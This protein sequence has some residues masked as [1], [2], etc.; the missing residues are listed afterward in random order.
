MNLLK[1]LPFR[2]KTAP[3]PPAVMASRARGAKAAV[4]FV[5]GFS[6]GLDSWDSFSQ[7]LLADTRIDDWDLLRVGYS[8]ALRVDIPHVWTDDPDLAACARL[9]RTAL[10]TSPLERYE[11]ITLVAHSMGGLV[12]QR[13]ILD[14]PA[15]RARLAHVV[16]YGTPSA[17]LRKAGA[18]QVFKHQFR[19]MARGGRFVNSVRKRWASQVGGAPPFDFMAV[20]GDR[21]AFV[22]R[23]S[24][25]DP[26]PDHQV[27]VIHGDHLQIIAPL[28]PEHLGYRVLVD[29]LSGAGRNP[30]QAAGARLAAERGEHQRVVDSLLPHAGELDDAM[31]ETLALSL[32]TLGRRE[33]AIALLNDHLDKRPESPSNLLGI[34]GGRVKRRWL[35]ERRASDLA[36][37]QQ[38]YGDGLAQAEA[39]GDH[40]QIHYHAINLA[41][42]ALMSVHPDSGVPAAAR[43]FATRAMAACDHAH[44]SAW[45]DATVGEAH[46][47]L[48][49]LAA[50][51]DAYVR[52]A[53][54]ARSVRD[55]ESMY[56]Q[57]VLATDHIFGEP[58]VRAIQDA[59]RTGRD[60]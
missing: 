40:G 1:L 8:T 43:T 30:T 15:L 16:L 57:A 58:G 55:R 4:V 39:A 59:F 28:S 27:A 21:D 20:A 36:R 37:A 11:R 17:G 52:A 35:V 12:V 49:N 53:E 6:G 22:P 45:R 3:S 56:A 24:S 9:L 29:L 54:S 44:P 48:G 25:I 13:A 50:A 51:A 23:E 19:D 42:L 7:L 5:H 38:L 34:L 14:D 46:L 26:F 60:A 32:D 33:E 2:R 31:L 47:V 41:F 10:R 18:G